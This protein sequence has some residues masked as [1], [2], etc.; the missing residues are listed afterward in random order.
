MENDSVNAFGQVA[1]GTAV[2]V[3]VIAAAVTLESAYPRTRRVAKTVLF[4]TTYAILIGVWARLLQ[5]LADVEFAFIR[6]RVGAA[7]I[8]LPERGW[9]IIL[10][11]ALLMFVADLIF[12]WVHRAQHKYEFLW[13]MHSFHHSDDDMNVTTAYRHY[14]LEKPFFLL[15]FYMP[16]GLIFRITPQVGSLFSAMFLFFGLFPHMNAPIELGPLTRVMLGPQVHRL[17]HSLDPAHFNANFAGAFPV[18]DL[19]FGTYRGPRPGEFPPAGLASMPGIPGMY[20]T[21]VR[22]RNVL[23]SGDASNEVVVAVP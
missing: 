13:A 10:S 20:D 5:P 3:V 18:W 1:A 2:L 14:W 23:A 17:H 9:P 15:M 21:L 12:Y 11:A 6:D 8:L 7:P 19:I 22:S 16:L 4:N